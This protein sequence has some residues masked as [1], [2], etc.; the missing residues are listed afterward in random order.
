LRG[1]VTEHGFLFDG[2]RISGDVLGLELEGL[3]YIVAPVGGGLAGN[4]VYK[5]YAD[6]VETCLTG[7]RHSSDGRG[8]GVGAVEE[9]ENGIMKRLD[10]DT[11]AVDAGGAKVPEAFGGEVVGV[12]LE[13]YFG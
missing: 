2:E 4:G 10:A 6:V 5:V 9:F 13:G 7:V 11:E 1:A 3:R 8:A 12:C